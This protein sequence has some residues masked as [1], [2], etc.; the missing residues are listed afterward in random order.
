MGMQHLRPKVRE[1][2]AV[3]GE[4]GTVSTQVL[5]RGHGGPHEADEK[6][7]GWGHG[8]NVELPHEAGGSRTMKYSPDLPPEAI[9]T[10][11]QNQ[12][13]RPPRSC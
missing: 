10:S 2:P 12:G 4:R 9:Q 11:L 13:A 7:C 5:G 1:W 3:C 8:R 6:L